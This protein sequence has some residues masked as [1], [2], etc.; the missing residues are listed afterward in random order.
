MSGGACLFLDLGTAMPLG[1]NKTLESS[2]N[3]VSLGSRMN[4]YLHRAHY[5]QPHLTPLGC[6]MRKTDIETV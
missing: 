6:H 3:R 5:S 1:I 4:S 2:N